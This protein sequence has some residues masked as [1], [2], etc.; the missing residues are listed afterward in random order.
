MTQFKLLK[1]SEVAAIF[2]VTPQTIRNWLKHPALAIFFSPSAHRAGGEPQAAFTT[3]DLYVFNTIWKMNPDETPWEDISRRLQEG[4]LDRELPDNAAL[5]PLPQDVP[6]QAEL[7][8]RLAVTSTELDREITRSRAKDDEIKKLRD[9]IDALNN[10]IIELERDKAGA[11]A[12]AEVVAQ[13]SESQREVIR[14]QKELEMRDAGWRP[15]TK[16]NS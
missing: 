9:Q 5:T 16:R 15:P 12:R 14:L 3:N 6:S 1:T 13:V 2:D 7:V 11:L 8:T 4:D 10:R